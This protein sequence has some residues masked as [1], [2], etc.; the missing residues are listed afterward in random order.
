MA[1]SVHLSDRDD[2]GGCMSSSIVIVDC[3][4]LF[5]KESGRTVSH[6]CVDT[7]FLSPLRY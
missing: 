1:T 4:G 7:A 5:V 2:C 3:D 6:L